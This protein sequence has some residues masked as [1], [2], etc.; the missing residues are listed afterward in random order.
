MTSD[1]TTPA[2]VRPPVEVALLGDVATRRDG[3][4]VPLP[5]PRARALLVALAL[6]PGRSRSAGSL[7]DDVW[8]DTPPRSP[9]NALHTQISRLRSAL[10]DGAIEAGPS[11]YRLVLAPEQV[12]V[13]LA[14]VL[15]RRAGQ[16]LADGDAPAALDA[17][18]D[19]RRLWRGEPGADLPVGGLADALAGEAAS[20]RRLLAGAE[21]GALIAVGRFDDALPI[22]RAA[23]TASPLDET[24]AARLMECLRGVGRSGEAL[25]VFAALR[26]RLAGRLGADPSPHLAELNAAILRGEDAAETGESRP[27][28][29]PAG[30]VGLRAAPNRLLGRASDLA[31]LERLLASSRVVTVLG[32]GGT[33]KTR[34]A[35]ALGH[36]VAARMPVALVELAPLRSGEDLIAAISGTLGLSENDLTPGGLTRTRIHDA[37]RRLR[38]ALAVR[39]SLLVLDNCEHLID[40]VADVVSDLIAASPHLTVLATSRAPLALTAESVYPLPPLAIEDDGSPA[41][42][43][44]RARAQAVRPS[45]RLDDVEVT[46]LCRTLDGLPLAIEL[47]AARVRTMSVEEINTRLADRFTLLRSRDRTT[48]E[49]HRTLRA[50]IE[51]SWNLLADAERATLRR[52]CRFPAGFTS[53]AAVSVAQWGEV[54]DVDDALEGLVNQSMLSVVEPGGSADADAAAAGAVG[55]R[56]HMLE[57]VREFGE[58]R[59]DAAETAEVHRRTVQWAEDLARNTFH[60]FVSGRQ[61]AAAHRVEAEHDNLLDVM[62]YALSAN[63]PAAVYTIFP[64][65]GGTWSLRGAHSEVF[66]WA[67]RVLELDGSGLGPADVPGDLLASAYVLIA[68]HAAMGRNLRAT[69]VARTRMRRLSAGRTDLGPSSRV[70]LSLVLMPGSG[71]GLARMLATAV[72]SPD[73][74]ARS[75]ALMARASLREN[76]G[77]LFGSEADAR[78]ALELAQELN[79]TWGLAMVLQHLGGL[80]SQAARYGEAVDLFR[81]SAE[82]LWELHLYDEGLQVRAFL[83][84]ALVGD[85]RIADA[86]AEL[87]A[88]VPLRA[89]AAGGASNENTPDRASLSASTA[90]AELAVGEVDRGLA[91]YRRAVEYTGGLEST[92]PA[93]PLEIMLAAAA[94]DAHVLAHRPEPVAALVQQL[95]AASV[96]RLGPSGYP[97]LPQTGAVACAV[98]GHRIVTGTGGGRALRLLALATR[99][100]ARQDYPS[101]QLVRHLDAARSVVGP[102]AVAAAL[103]SVQGTPRAAAH[104]EILD[105]LAEIP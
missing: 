102:D 100:R 74:G 103:T 66:A 105:L 20:Y 94:V 97:D 3:K 45:V 55:V 63:L 75:A 52:L 91:E 67:P 77:D 49:R 38:D 42:E 25:D 80:C 36:T 21:L 13:A 37:R 28:R 39:P 78:Q 87:A 56:Y 5:G 79:D 34:V 47:A 4:L 27:P 88:L 16:D 31:A 46:R 6:R 104:R 54:L 73:P 15:A 101:M 62:R 65:L 11:G 8:G 96:Q 41:V 18:Q 60:D 30:A 2:P 51:W 35:H 7:V 61:V 83:V 10:P 14:R 1:P 12:D 70:N 71:R 90:E 99:V 58:D 53:D 17:V 81:S 33:G 76:N 86:R 95:T 57:T 59:S 68:A 92:L 84:A 43:L 50:V 69:A 85:G 32:P 22:A 98:A 48:P 89:Q 64:V 40:D 72:R 24:A 9:A 19:A 26:V 44:F 82:G 93:D 23:A 29:S